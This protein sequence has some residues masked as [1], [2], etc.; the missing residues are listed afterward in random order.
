MSIEW[1]AVH[2]LVGQEEKAKANLEKRIKAFGL[3]DKIFQVL[4]PTEEVVE[5]REGGKKEV[6]RKK[7]FPG[8]LFIQM[9]L[10][11]EE[12]PNEA[13]EVVR[14]TPGITGFVGA[15]MRPVPLS[16]DEVRHI[17]EVSGL[18]G[19]VLPTVPSSPARG[20]PVLLQDRIFQVKEAP[21][22]Q[23]AFREGDQVRVVSGPFADFTGTVTEINPE[24]GKVK[25]MV[26]IF[27]RSTPVELDFLKVEKL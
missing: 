13:W 7:L 14:G 26:T 10:G 9:D 5:L 12:E 17:L 16:P 6:V 19:A 3:Q 8:Y 20:S 24:R 27:G 21:K 4:I 15:G 25:V 11:D 1:Y 23:V 2:T 18:L 22:A